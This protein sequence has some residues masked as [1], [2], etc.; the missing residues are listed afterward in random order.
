[1]ES[2]S[3]ARAYVDERCTLEGALD[4]MTRRLP[5]H[6]RSRDDLESRRAG[7][8]LAAG[9][10]GEFVNFEDGFHTCTNYNATFACL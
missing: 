10:Q 5:R 3:D 6:P 4:R 8:S 2:L 1:M 7:G 9:E